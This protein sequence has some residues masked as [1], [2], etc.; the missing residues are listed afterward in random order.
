MDRS[1]C[2]DSGNRENCGELGGRVRC[3]GHGDTGNNSGHCDTGNNGGHGDAGNNSGH[4]DTGNNSGHCDTENNSGHC[5]TGN[6]S[7]HGDAGNNSGHGDVGNNSGHDDTGNN[8]GH[9]DTG[10]NSGHGHGDTGSSTGHV[11]DHVDSDNTPGDKVT[12]APSLGL[13][14]VCGSRN[15]LCGSRASIARYGSRLTV[16]TEGGSSRRG[17]VR[18]RVS[19][20]TSQGD[21]DNSNN[22][23]KK[24]SQISIR[25][26]R[27]DRTTRLLIVILCLFLISEFPQVYFYSHG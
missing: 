10:N 12:T 1:S 17:S 27:T 21:R 23:Q 7:G 25:K 24:I 19:T 9:G 20:V 5:D 3:S 4:G 8:S 15:M 26:L 13:S 22:W 2:G 14:L 18:L 16:S 11:N 6:N